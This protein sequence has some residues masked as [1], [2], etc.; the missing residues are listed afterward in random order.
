MKVIIDRF[1]ND[2]AVVEIDVGKTIN[3]PKELF[4]NALE[5]DVFN[6]IL[7]KRETEKRKENIK[8]LIDDLF[9]D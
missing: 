1:E 5:G 7:D 4:P 3:V 2:I 8:N 6:I 9:I